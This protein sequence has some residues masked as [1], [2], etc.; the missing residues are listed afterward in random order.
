MCLIALLKWGTRLWEIFSCFIIWDKV[1][2]AWSF[3]IA[4]LA[5]EGTSCIY[6]SANHTRFCDI[7]SWFA[8]SY[9]YFCCWVRQKFQNW[10]AT[11][12]NVTLINNDEIFVVECMHRKYLSTWTLLPAV[13]VT[14]LTWASHFKELWYVVPSTFNSQ[15][16]FGILPRRRSLAF[17]FPKN[18]DRVFS[19]LIAKFWSWHQAFMWSTSVFTRCMIISSFNRWS[20]IKRVKSSTYLISIVS[21]NTYCSYPTWTSKIYVATTDLCGTPNLTW[22]LFELGAQRK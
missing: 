8:Q 4:I 17:G 1:F 9:H 13:L 20:G 21:E 16:S 3:R 5:V 19:S 14:T 18:I 7:V 6:I 12:C 15:T 22:T 2:I 11:C 10:N